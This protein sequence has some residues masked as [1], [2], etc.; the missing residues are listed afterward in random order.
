MQ[1]R[2]LAFAGTMREFRQ[3]LRI[4]RI[5]DQLGIQPVTYQNARLEVNQYGES[6]N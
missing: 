2:M 4:L 1:I 3:M 6:I 5:M